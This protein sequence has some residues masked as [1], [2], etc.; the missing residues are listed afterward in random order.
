MNCFAHALPFLDQPYY[1]VGACIPD[2]LSSADRKCRAREKRA[3][4][5][6]NH[7]DPVVAAV[8]KGVVQHH[9][10]DHWF[11]QTPAFNE[12]SMKFA[13]EIRDVLGNEAG[14]RPG[15]LGHIVVELILDS[16]LHAA[17]PGKLE[18]FYQQV[19][20]VD[21]L[22]VQS[23][24]NQFATRP[25]DKLPW[26]YKRFMEERFL[27]DY[28][29]DQRLVYRVNHVFKR[30]KLQPLDERIL[31]WLPSCRERVTDRTAELL[32]EYPIP[33]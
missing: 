20:G 27:F 30:V 13:V 11:H 19:A 3:V 29:N 32:A 10:D 18:Y 4:E 22:K 28:G 24:I 1:A 26:Y 25:T 9:Q 6:T 16:I 5:Y 21:P 7:A 15:L 33:V 14:F 2:W 31:S 12:L 8:A 23:A 17:N